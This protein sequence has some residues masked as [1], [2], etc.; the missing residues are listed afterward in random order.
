MISV[1]I[2]RWDLGHRDKWH[3]KMGAKVGG[4]QLTKDTRTAPIPRSWEDAG[5]R[6]LEPSEAA[7]E[8]SALPTPRF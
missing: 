6:P 7:E 1:L 3:E 4:V 8:A 2:R 5:D